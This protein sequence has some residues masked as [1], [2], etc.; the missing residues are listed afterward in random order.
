MERLAAIIVKCLARPI[1]A[2]KGRVLMILLQR[3]SE[4]GAFRG[5]RET[6]KSRNSFGWQTGDEEAEARRS[7]LQ[8][9]KDFQSFILLTFTRIL[10]KGAIEGPQVGTVLFPINVSWD[11]HGFSASVGLTKAPV[12]SAGPF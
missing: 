9:S 10:Q 7:F 11:V 8:V 1:I 12:G 6:T 2:G 5:R 3:P 4:P